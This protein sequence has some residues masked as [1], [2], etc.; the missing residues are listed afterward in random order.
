[1]AAGLFLQFNT[2]LGTT[3]MWTIDKYIGFVLHLLLGFGLACELPLVIIML[4]SMGLIRPQQLKTYRRHVVVGIFIMAMLLT[5]PDPTTQLM[6]AI[7][8]YLL[9]E[10]CIW[11]LYLT[12]APGAEKK[13]NEEPAANQ[14]TADPDPEAPADEN[15][16]HELKE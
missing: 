11:I 1:V 3:A 5:P 6:M 13:E 8:L 2:T 15:T 14:P 9:Y 10:C 7:P 16:D 12:G 4:G